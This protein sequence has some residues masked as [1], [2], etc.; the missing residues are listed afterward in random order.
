MIE[1]L[2]VSVGHGFAIARMSA[3]LTEARPSYSYPIVHLAQDR[4]DPKGKSGVCEPHWRPGVNVPQRTVVCV[5]V[6]GRGQCGAV[7]G[8]IRQ[9]R[10]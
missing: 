7:L 10:L 1:R 4:R 9:D 5:R 6:D 2:L 3:L 8:R